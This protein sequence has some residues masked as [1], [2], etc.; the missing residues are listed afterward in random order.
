MLIMITVIDSISTIITLMIAV[1]KHNE[2]ITCLLP[3]CE[4]K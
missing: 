4:T 3:R 1:K 2:M